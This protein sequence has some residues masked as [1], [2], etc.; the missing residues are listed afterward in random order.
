MKPGRLSTLANDMMGTARHLVTGPEQ[1]SEVQGI[2]Q[3]SSPS[4]NPV[5][6]YCLAGDNDL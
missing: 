4:G 3:P 2:Q 5:G 6:R 1:K